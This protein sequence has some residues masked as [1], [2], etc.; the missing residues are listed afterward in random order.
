[1]E[2]ITTHKTEVCGSSPQWPTTS[3]VLEQLPI[4]DLLMMLL[5]EEGRRKLD[6]R[7]KTN[8]QL[9]P[10]YYDLVSA[11]LSDKYSYESKRLLEKFRAFIEDIHQLP[12]SQS[13]SSASLRTES[14]TRK[15]DIPTY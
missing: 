9:F 8:Q 4:R 2:N 5:G 7:T 10:D 1:M 6:N 11:T 12:I 14:P 15:L 13:S 3:R